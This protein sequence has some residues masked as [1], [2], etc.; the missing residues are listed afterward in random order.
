MTCGCGCK[1]KTNEVKVKLKKMYEDVVT[2]TYAHEGDSGMDVYARE[3]IVLEPNSR[4][5]FKLG[6]KTAIPSGYEIQVRSKSGLALN[7]GLIVLNSPGTVDC[8]PYGTQI[9]TLN[10]T[11]SA[12]SLLED[13]A[14]NV[15][16]SYNEEQNVVEE[17]IVEDVWEISGT[18]MIRI[19]TENNSIEI[20]ESKSVF[21]RRGW[22][23]AGMLLLSDE[24]LS[25]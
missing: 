20:P 7:K 8:V 4:H 22:V 19:D 11:I 3:D 12:E 6:F 5:L 24:I 17:D 2:P 1:C 15:I 14:S 16:L 9:R 13:S 21:T 10:G 18:N 25:F 23:E